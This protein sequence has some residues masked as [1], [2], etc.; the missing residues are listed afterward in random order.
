M[1]GAKSPHYVINDKCIG[2]GTCV[3]VCRFQAVA[4]V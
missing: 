4:V 2:C 3:E 1:G